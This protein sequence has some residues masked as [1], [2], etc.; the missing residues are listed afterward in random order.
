VGIALFAVALGS[1]IASTTRRRS[2][3]YDQ[4]QVRAVIHNAAWAY[5]AVSTANRVRHA[6]TAEAL[7]Q[8]AGQL[9][10]YALR[11]VILQPGQQVRGYVYLPRFDH[12]DGLEVLAPVGRRQVAFSFVQSH[13]RR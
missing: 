7:A 13:Q 10:E 6:A 4:A 11:R 3:T 12:A 8:R 5:Q 2:E 1:D 9:S